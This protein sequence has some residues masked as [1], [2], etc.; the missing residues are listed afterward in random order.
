[1]A[2]LCGQRPVASSDH[3]ELPQATPQQLLSPAAAPHPVPISPLH[4]SGAAQGQ[5]GRMPVILAAGGKRGW[6]AIQ[7]TRQ[8]VAPGP[9]SRMQ[10]TTACKHHT[11]QPRTH[12][13]TRQPSRVRVLARCS[14]WAVCRG[15]LGC[16]GQTRQA[17]NTRASRARTRCSSCAVCLATLSWVGNLVNWLARRLT[18]CRRWRL[19]GRRGLE[20]GRFEA[21]LDG[22]LVGA[23]VARLRSCRGAECGLGLWDVP[24][25]RSL[26]LS[27]RAPRHAI[28]PGV[29]QAGRQEDGWQVPVCLAT[30]ASLPHHK[31]QSASPQAASGRRPAAGSAARCR[32]GRAA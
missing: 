27:R 10:S 15:A 18:A 7:T 20:K 2:Q 16:A 32:T 29:H 8:P 26:L 31:C 14:P 5:R 17:S 23:Q 19:E 11:R 22:E 13:S 3:Q 9:A 25:L 1:M 21:S 28:R 6:Q 12:A 4:H 30:S 24:V